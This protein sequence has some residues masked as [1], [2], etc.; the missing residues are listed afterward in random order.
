MGYLG[1]QV[2]MSYELTRMLPKDDPANVEYEHFKVQFG[3]DGSVI[4]V[5]IEDPDLFTLDHFDDWYDLCNK[6]E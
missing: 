3:Q 1:L 4:L 2:K 6:V 5:A